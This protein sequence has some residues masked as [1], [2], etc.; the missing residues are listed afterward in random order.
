[1]LLWTLSGVVMMYKEYPELGEQEKIDLLPVL[2]LDRCCALPQSPMLRGQTYL[3]ARLEMLETTPVLRLLTQS[4]GWTSVNLLD[5]STVTPVDRERADSLAEQ[6]S[7]RYL[8]QT[9]LALRGEIYNDQWTVYGG[10]N[11]HRPLFKYRVDDLQKTEFYISS[12]SGEVVQLTSAEQ[13][14]WGYLGAV[15]H[16]LYPTRLRQHTALWS[17]VVIWLTLTGIFLT[18]IGVYIGLRQYRHRK[19]GR[20]SPYRGFAFYHHYAGLIFGILTLTWVF[21]GLFSMNPWGLLEGEG[22]GAEAARLSGRSLEWPE[23]EQLI[24]VAVVDES[25]LGIRRLELFVQNERP[26]VLAREVLDRQRRL[27]PGTLQ[28]DR[29]TE[30]QF[31]ALAQR[32]QPEV[33]IAAITLLQEGDAY[34][35]SHHEIREFPV[36]RII[37]DE[38]QQRRYYLS[39][40]SGQLLQKIDPELRWYRWLFYGLHRGDFTLMLRARPLWD[41]LMLCFLSGVALVCGTGCVMGYRRLSRSVK[42]WSDVG[43]Y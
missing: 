40:V 42:T 7:L 29:L 10:Y 16:W 36:Y 18:T 41:L 33:G 15:I 37:L 17:Q 34:Y 9:G 14:L 20:W 22:A 43:D 5:G 3:A 8:N 27:D 30:T 38:P 21:S 39:A 24:N 13:R 4:R 19:G 26:V 35:Y 32:L 11:P 28:P 2:N 31:F 23:I 12:L 25:M 1:M 6:F